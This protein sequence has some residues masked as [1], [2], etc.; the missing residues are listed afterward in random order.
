MH[1]VAIN[2]CHGLERRGGTN[3]VSLCCLG[4]KMYFNFNLVAQILFN[5]ALV[6]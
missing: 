6:S 5:L 3:V 2:A 1:K 4:H